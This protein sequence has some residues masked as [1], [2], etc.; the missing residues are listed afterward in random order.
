MARIPSF[1]SQCRPHMGIQRH[2]QKGFQDN[3][4]Q[5]VPCLF[6][7]GIRIRILSHP[8]KERNHN[9]RFFST[10]S[11]ISVMSIDFMPFERSI[12]ESFANSFEILSET[13]S[14]QD[15]ALA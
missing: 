11:A 12:L 5:H 6:E 4:V 15:N 2:I 10:T 14:S 7:F 8:I 13:S 3:N 1:H 9:L